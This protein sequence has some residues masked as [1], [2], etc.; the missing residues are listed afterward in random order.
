MKSTSTRTGALV[1]GL[2][3]ISLIG[4]SALGAQLAALPF[5]PWEFFAWLGTVLPDLIVSAA[6]ALAIAILLLFNFDVDASIVIFGQAIACLFLLLPGMVV[7]GLF[8]GTMNKR[9]AKS[10][11]RAG[12]LLGGVIGLFLASV[13]MTFGNSAANPLISLLWLVLLFVGW[14]AALGYSC[15]Y[16]RPLLRVQADGIADQIESGPIMTRRQFVGRLGLLTLLVGVA[17][18]GLGRLVAAFR[19]EQAVEGM[20]ASMGL[21]ASFPAT[22]KAKVYP[23]SEK[24]KFPE[25]EYERFQPT[26]H[27]FG[28]CFSGGGTRSLSASLGQMRG[29]YAAGLLQSVGA[30]SA[31]SGGSWFAT[32]YSYA[33]LKID[34]QSLLG[35]ILQPEEIT[36]QNLAQID[37]QCIASPLLD[38]TTANFSSTKNDLMA[39]ITLSESQ[40]FNRLYARLLN[41]LL[42]KPFELDDPYKFFTLNAEVLARI[43]AENPL[44]SANDFYTMRPKRPFLIAGATQLYPVGENQGLRHFEFSPLYVGSPQLFPAAAPD[45][46]DIGG[47]YVETFAFD[48]GT[49]STPDADQYVTVPTPDPIFLL[50]DLIGSSGAA[51]GIILGGFNKPEWFAKFSHWPSVNIGQQPATTYSFVDGGPLENLGIVPLLRRQYPIILAFANSEHPIGAENDL[52]VDGISHDISRLFGF[53]PQYTRGNNENTQLFPASKF[54]ALADGLKAA[55]ANGQATTFIDS[56]P[57][58]QPNFFDIPS[59]PDKRDVTIVWFYNDINQ[60]WKSKLS[61]PV[62]EL[63]NSEEPTNYLANFPN[64]RTVGQ[65]NNL[66]GLP[67]ILQLTAQQINLLAHMS[68]YTVMSVA[69]ELRGL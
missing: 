14:G 52:M 46:A 48:S 31:V 44:L 47:G 15:A 42:L 10:D 45:G 26:S 40:A 13:S 63:L 67:E 54:Q 35:P 36:R 37:P 25:F 32:I 51:P 43:L 8:F 4:L 11:L 2:L 57:I 50:S 6:F 62:Q 64:Y 58:I 1:G 34:E 69:E 27:P 30:I 55:K 18:G 7:G 17:S 22:L 19:K 60:E 56:Y 12:L 65:N 9:Q 21:P 16:M 3:S 23:S 61:P 39:A 68:C 24:F 53:N 5:L 59:Y 66:S 28:L 29:L 41:E 38:A 49:P 33:P 20:A